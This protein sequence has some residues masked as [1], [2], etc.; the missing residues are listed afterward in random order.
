VKLF[1]WSTRL[2]EW[3]GEFRAPVEQVSVDRDLAAIRSVLTE[4]EFHN[5]FS[6]GS[7]MTM[8][9]AIALALEE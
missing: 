5:V 3:R 8:D 1:S 6:E 9:Q 7:R 4:D 2:R